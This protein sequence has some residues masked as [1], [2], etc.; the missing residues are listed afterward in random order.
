M[1]GPP[2][3]VRDALKPLSYHYFFTFTRFISEL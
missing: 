1:S 2:S 3:R